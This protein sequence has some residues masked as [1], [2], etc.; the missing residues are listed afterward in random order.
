M[1]HK[2]RPPGPLG[3]NMATAGVVKTNGFEMEY[4]KFGNG[5]RIFVILPGLSIKSVMGAKDSIEDA[6]SIMKDDFTTYVFD[7][8][9]SITDDYSIYDMADD[10]AAVMKELGL[11]DIYLFGASQGGMIAMAIAIRYPE[12]VKK[13]VLGST[14]P[15]VKPGQREIIDRWIGLAQKKDREGLCREYGKEIYPPEVYEQYKELFSDMAK[16]VTDN[17]LER[18]VILAKSILD[19]D[20]SDELKNIECPV[21]A[22]GDFE[23]PVLDSDATMEIA[24]NLDHRADFSLYMYTGYGHAAFDTAPD[25]KKRMLDFLL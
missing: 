10:T 9:K 3:E 25:Y 7:R 12:L 11:K 19:Y 4:C 24:E 22:V 6:Y 13:A 20:V 8:R 16:N 15:H 1:D 17:E 18:F 21:L 5:D 14:S 2:P 23:D